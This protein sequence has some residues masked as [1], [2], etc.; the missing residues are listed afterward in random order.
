MFEIQNVIEHTSCFSVMAI[1]WTFPQPMTMLSRVRSGSQPY[2]LSES[3]PP[4]NKHSPPALKHIHL[5]N[6]FFLFMLSYNRG[7]ELSHLFKF[8]QRWLAIAYLIAWL[9][10]FIDETDLN[11]SKSQKLIIAFG[12][13]LPLANKNSCGWKSTITD[14]PLWSKNSCSNFPTRKSHN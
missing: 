11:D 7:H 1:S 5:Q 9:F 10:S 6:V 3:W 14:D 8:M 4:A 2:I 12:A 13:P